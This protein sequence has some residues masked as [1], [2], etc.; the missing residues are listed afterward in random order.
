MR[1]AAERQ[2]PMQ[3]AKAC[4]TTFKFDLIGVSLD[5]K[6]PPEGGLVV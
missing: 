2:S 3:R 5:L 4:R 1:D 6:K